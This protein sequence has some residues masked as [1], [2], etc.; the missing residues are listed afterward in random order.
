MA[1]RIVHSVY[2]ILPTFP[3]PPLPLS[4][5]PSP[6]QNRQHTEVISP[7]YSYIVN[8]SIHHTI[9][10]TF[11]AWHLSIIALLS[12]DEFYMVV[13][14]CHCF[15]QVGT[16]KCVCDRTRAIYYTTHGKD[17]QT[18]LKSQNQFGY[19]RFGVFYWLNGKIRYS[20]RAWPIVCFVNSGFLILHAIHDIVFG[21]DP[22]S[23]QNLNL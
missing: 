8:Y 10:P 5:I 6:L 12:T 23:R 4:S 22:E 9:H 13:L 2:C 18:D 16:T 21:S 7:A 14:C 20:L 11:P 1:Y 3:L 17:V 15:P 19:A